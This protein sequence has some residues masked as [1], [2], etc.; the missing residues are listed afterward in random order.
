MSEPVQLSAAG[1][2]T[3]AALQAAAA[4]ALERKQRLGQH[5]V[6]WVDGRPVLSGG[7]TASERASLL[8]ILAMQPLTDAPD[9]QARACHLQ[10]MLAQLPASSQPQ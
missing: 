6:T 10:T 9:S 8:K 7:D 3:L 1:Q 2:R 4:A 5:A